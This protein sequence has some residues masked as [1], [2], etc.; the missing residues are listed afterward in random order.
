L[1]GILGKS[2]ARR[3]FFMNAIRSVFSVLSNLAASLNNF[4][5]VIDVAAGRLRQSQALDDAAPALPH[6][7]VIDADESALSTKRSGRTSKAAV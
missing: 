5:G 6:G 1:E 4:A 2:V 3:S 7:E